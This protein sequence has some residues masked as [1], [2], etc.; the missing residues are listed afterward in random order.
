MAP[1]TARASRSTFPPDMFDT[2][3]F[4]PAY[5]APAYFPEEIAPS[6][7]TTGLRDWDVLSDIRDRL[8]A[9]G[10]FDG[11]HL[12]GLP[13]EYGRSAGETRMAV[14]TLSG[15]DDADDWDDAEDV[16]IP[17]AV[18][19]TLT[20]FVRQSDPESRDREADRLA[21]VAQNV[22][23]GQ[24]LAGITLP[25]LTKIRRGRWERSP[26]PERRLV[27]MGEFTYLVNAFDGHDTTE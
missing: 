25:G 20:L 1:A 9:T 3:Y 11:V 5:F 22:L 8:I 17:R 27:L 18:A 21:N 7:L 4:P 19:W 10:A 24:S 15:W 14:C 12:S 13:A 6:I 23:D 2:V 26:A 16:S